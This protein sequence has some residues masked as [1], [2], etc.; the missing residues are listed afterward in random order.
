[1]AHGPGLPVG[2][3]DLWHHW[4]FDF[5]VLVPLFVVHWLYGRGVLRLWARAGTGRGVSRT[6]VG[7]FFA[8][9]VALVVALVTPLDQLGETLLTAHMVQHGLLIAVA[10][11][12]LLFGRPGAALPWGLPAR[13]RRW[14]TRSPVFRAGARRFA[15]LLHPLVAAALHGAVLWGW[16]AP[17]L[18]DAALENRTL[19]WIEH[20]TFFG[21]AMP[22]LAEPLPREPQR[23]DDPGRARRRLRDPRPRRPARGAHHLRAVSPVLLVRRADGAVGPHPPRGPAA[24]RSRHVGAARARLP[25]RL[26]RPRRS[27]RPR[28]RRPRPRRRAGTAPGGRLIGAQAETPAPGPR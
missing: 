14:A 10:P 20:L 24:R 5:R 4:T 1:L 19:H 23:R 27:P 22:F 15:V 11:P 18:F 28:P 7:L 13:L 12:L 26:P 6:R 2:P 17:A 21:T 25:R 3:G 16:H 8:G 9:E